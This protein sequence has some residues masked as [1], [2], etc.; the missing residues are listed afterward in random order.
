MENKK[1]IK[2]HVLK[3]HHISSFLEYIKLISRFVF[4]LVFAYVKAGS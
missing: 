2:Q 3:V 4:Q 1:K